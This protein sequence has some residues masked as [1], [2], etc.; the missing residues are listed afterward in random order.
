[1][2]IGNVFIKKLKVPVYHTSLWIIVSPNVSRAI[3]VVEDIIDYKI[4]DKEFKRSV[5]ALTHSEQDHDGKM[6]LMIFVN[7]DA[8]PGR[9][10]HE[11]H[12]AV[13]YIMSWHG[14]KPSFSNDEAESY[15]LEQIVDRV[16]KTIKQYENTSS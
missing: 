9:I 8:K 15:Y 14:V 12:H 3:E 10:A 7:V 11:C 5:D 4:A 1:M 13:N 6:R 16:H 2:R